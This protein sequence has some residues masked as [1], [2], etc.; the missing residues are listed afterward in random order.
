MRFSTLA[1]NSITERVKCKVWNDTVANLSLLALGTSAPEILL[2]VIEIVGNNFESGSLGPG[3]IVGSAA[4]NLLFIS[5]IC[6]YAIPEGEIRR[7]A[8][9]KVWN[10]TVANLSL[11]ALGTSAP[12][13]LLSVIEIVGN[14]FESGSLGPGTIVGSAAFN[15]LFISAIC[16][17]AIPEGEIRRIASVKKR[18][19][20]SGLSGRAVGHQVKGQKFEPQSGPSQIFI[21]PPCPPSTKWIAGSLKTR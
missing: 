20:N 10:D 6:I 7:I 19:R 8:S 5:A 11:L 9:V 16:I 15:L 18:K 2:S 17:Y 21:A 3:T 12:E 1:S 13:I 4:F 14:N